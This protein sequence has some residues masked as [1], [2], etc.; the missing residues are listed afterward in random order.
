[1][2]IV[3]NTI[4]VTIRPHEYEYIPL[5]MKNR[6]WALYSTY[7]ISEVLMTDSIV[8]VSFTVPDDRSVGKDIVGVD[9]NFSTVDMTTV[10][11]VSRDITG[12]ETKPVRGIVR[13]QNDFSRR[14][15]K[16]QK[17]ICNPQKRN[18]K[19]RQARGRQRRRIRDELHKQ[20][21]ALVKEHPDATFVFEDLTGIRKSGDDRGKWFKTCLNRWPYSEFQ[22]MVE[23]KSSNRTVYVNPRGTSSECPVCGETVKHP[24]WKISRCDKCDR[25]YDRDRLAS[26]AI[27]LRGLDLCGD[28]FPVSASASWQP[29]KNEYLYTWSL[30]ETPGAC[31]TE[32]ASAAN[33]TV[34]NNIA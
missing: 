29:L 30:P 26:L 17:S 15:Q 5:N 27:T 11:T 12:V 4:R 25:D 24:S 19:L 3:G 6:K 34:H 33:E 22:R 1:V 18:R 21:T 14:R 8:S 2:K 23:Y 31:M 28:P 9:V 20:S 16:L 32:T 13:I 10:D 7:R